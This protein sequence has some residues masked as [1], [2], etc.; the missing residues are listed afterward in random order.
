MSE[1]LAAD[2]LPPFLQPLKTSQA[3][4][5]SSSS[6]LNATFTHHR[7]SRSAHVLWWPH[8][9]SSSTILIFVPGNPG[10]LNFYIPFLAS[11]HN[12][13]NHTLPILAHSHLGHTPGLGTGSSEDTSR[14]SLGLIA[15]VESL[16]ELI[17][18]VKSVYSKVIIAGHSVGCWLTMQVLKE[19]PELIQSIILLFPTI[20]HIKSTPN[21]QNLAR[22]FKPPFPSIIS[23]A[24]SLTRLIPSGLL[25][26]MFSHWPPEQVLVLRSLLNSPSCIYASLTM[27]HDEME[28]IQ[29]LD[30]DTLR[31]YHHRI[32]L[33]FAEFDD[34]VGKEKKEILRAFN[35][36][37][38]AVKI[39]HGRQDIP[40]AFCINHG[41]E[42]AS[43]CF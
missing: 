13:S 17:D 12:K 41:E 20:S 21:G 37:E 25:S 29:D 9:S 33:Y 31:R 40:H 42:L 34:W 18:A 5:D 38:D 3:N 36:D 2:S 11:V 10:L 43:Q 23:A 30:V 16:L 14:L 8:T 35:P 26:L 27:A 24:S 28:T 4:V 1:S 6:H 15:Q 19:R 7:F 22:L 32:H 39:V